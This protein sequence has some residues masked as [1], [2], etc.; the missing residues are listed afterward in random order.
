VVQVFRAEQLAALVVVGLLE[1]APQRFVFA[2][3]GKARVSL[4]H[5]AVGHQAA[6]AL[7]N[8]MARICYATLRDMVAFQ[9]EQSLTKKMNRQAFAMPA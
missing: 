3:A 1:A 7:A 2:L 4:S 6:C 8:K 5:Q 9:P